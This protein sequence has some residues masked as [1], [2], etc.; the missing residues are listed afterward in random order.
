VPLRVRSGGVGKLMGAPCAYLV[1]AAHLEPD[2]K[3]SPVASALG[4]ELLTRASWLG[5]ESVKVLERGD[6]ARPLAAAKT[7]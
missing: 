5:L 4:A 3:A 2:A 1:L 6:R 7:S